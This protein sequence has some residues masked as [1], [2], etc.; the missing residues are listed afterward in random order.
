MTTRTPR[1]VSDDSSPEALSPCCGNQEEEPIHLVAEYEQ[2]CPDELDKGAIK[3]DDLVR[4]DEQPAGSAVDTAAE[5][6]E[7]TAAKD[8]SEKKKK[9]KRRRKDYSKFTWKPKGKRWSASAYVP[10]SPSQMKQAPQQRRRQKVSVPAAYKEVDCRI[11]PQR[12]I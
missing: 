3:E 6:T 10:V 11:V 2:L 7:T 12:K 4:A 9:K 1:P 8:Q 5:A